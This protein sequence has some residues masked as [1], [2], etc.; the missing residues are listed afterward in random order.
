MEAQNMI[1]HILSFW[2]I[3]ILLAG[4]AV[5]ADSNGTAWYGGGAGA[6]ACGDFRYEFRKAKQKGINSIPYA[7]DMQSY[8]MYV[9]GFRTGFNHLA[10]NTCDVF[11]GETEIN[12]ILEQVSVYCL[13][14]PD[15]KFSS[16]L[17]SVAQQSMSTSLRKCN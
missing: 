14:N 11:G 9:L 12:N 3:F 16:A 5:A 17:V 6:I 2:I 7:N 13:S 1:K 8:V 15:V 10:E 4:K